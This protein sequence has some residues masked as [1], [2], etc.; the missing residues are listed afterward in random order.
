[1]QQVEKALKEFKPVDYDVKKWDS[2]VQAFQTK[3]V[4]GVVISR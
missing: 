4:S 1:M 2:A 3:A